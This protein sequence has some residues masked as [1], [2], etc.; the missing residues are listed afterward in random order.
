MNAIIHIKGT[1]QLEGEAPDTIE[2]TTRGSLEATD[3]GGWQLKYEETEESGLVG[4]TTLLHITGERVILERT[5]A[6]AGIL[7]LEKRRRHHSHYTT[8][9]GMLDLGTYTNQLA[10]SLT[11]EGGELFFAYTLGFNGGI[12]SVHTVHITVEEEKSSCPVS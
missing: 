12:N 3:G 1:Q 5:G 7:V 4:T 10:C 2:M 6:N 8:P 9:Y 11:D